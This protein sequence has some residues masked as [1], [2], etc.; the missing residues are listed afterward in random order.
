[1]RCEIGLML[2]SKSIV[3]VKMMMVVKNKDV[4]KKRALPLACA[5]PQKMKLVVMLTL[6]T[7]N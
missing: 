4:E 2:L 5:A 1:M 6:T 7:W 3:E